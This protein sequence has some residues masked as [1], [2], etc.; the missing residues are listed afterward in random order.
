MSIKCP[1]K[2]HVLKTCYPGFR[3]DTLLGLLDSET[4]DPWNRGVT[5]LLGGS[6]VAGATI[7]KDVIPADIWV[8][9]APAE[10]F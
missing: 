3:G 9:R 8:W 6:G 1:L 5:A 7:L 2:V 4:S 10:G